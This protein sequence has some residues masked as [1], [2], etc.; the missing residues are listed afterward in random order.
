MLGEDASTLRPKSRAPRPGGQP[1]HSALNGTA[2]AVLLILASRMA[3]R[4]SSPLA[5]SSTGKG[6]AA[7]ASS[8]PASSREASVMP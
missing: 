3:W 8:A 2:H 1:E 6:L 7:T 4:I 5:S